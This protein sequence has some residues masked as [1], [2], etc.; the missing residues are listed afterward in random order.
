VGEGWWWWLEEAVVVREVVVVVEGGE[1]RFQGKE[2]RHRC[3]GGGGRAADLDVE[4]LSPD[5]PAEHLLQARAV[6]AH[7]AQALH[8]G[9]HPRRAAARR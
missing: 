2:A 7:R 1:I 6:E 5:R 3:G 4:D 9:R 8:G